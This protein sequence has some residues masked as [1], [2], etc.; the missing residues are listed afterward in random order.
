MRIVW[1]TIYL[2]TPLSTQQYLHSA[3]NLQRHLSQFLQTQRTVP[4]IPSRYSRRNTQ[5]IRLSQRT[6]PYLRH[7]SET[8]I[9]F[10]VGI[11]SWKNQRVHSQNVRVFEQLQNWRQTLFCSRRV[12]VYI[13]IVVQSKV[14]KLQKLNAKQ[15]EQSQV[16]ER[17]AKDTK[18]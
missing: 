3:P 6:R 5:N 18:R 8:D 11:K 12:Q 14:I 2:A 10:I 13:S 1:D 16:A 7:L 4:G 15:S 9:E 17:P